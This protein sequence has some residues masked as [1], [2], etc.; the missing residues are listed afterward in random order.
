MFSRSGLAVAG[1]GVAL[2]VALAGCGTL[3]GFL[4]PDFLSALG[5]GTQIASLPGDAPGL[6]ISVE[7]RTDRW[8]Q[9]MVSYRDADE[10]VQNFTSMVAP[11]DKTSQMLVCPITEITMGDV[12]DLS[13]AGAVVFLMDDVVDSGELLNAPYLEVDPFGVL[14]REGVNY[15][16]GD[17]LLFTVKSSSQTRS[18]YQTFVYIRRSGTS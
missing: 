9:I 6:L 8:V 15:D 10:T 7:N 1:V 2:V 16:C 4:N 3:T 14:L 17:E 12:G 5:S 18:N 13:Q 11:E